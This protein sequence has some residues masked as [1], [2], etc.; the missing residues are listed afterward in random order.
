M[1]TSSSSA[2]R[3]SDMK[4][5]PMDLGYR[6]PKAFCTVSQEPKPQHPTDRRDFNRGVADMLSI[7]RFVQNPVIAEMIIRRSG[8]SVNR[9]P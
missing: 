9:E 6:L 5:I 8:P 7:N 2:T 3:V 1:Q 4:I